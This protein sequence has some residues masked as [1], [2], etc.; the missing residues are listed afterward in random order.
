MQPHIE[1]T[2]LHATLRLTNRSQRLIRVCTEGG[3]FS[4]GGA[5][6]S[7]A[8]FTAGM[9]KSDTPPTYEFARHV[10]E[11][12]PG[13]VVDLP[14]SFNVADAQAATRLSAS[15]AVEPEIAAA[16]DIQRGICCRDPVIW[17]NR[18]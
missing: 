2:S 7:E 9:Y 13:A 4:S 18:P 8:V 15:Y 12:A 14:I 1:G 16:L 6:Q 5:K 3:Q 17:L 11:L 10:Q